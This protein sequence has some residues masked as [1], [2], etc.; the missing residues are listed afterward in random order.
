VRK[1]VFVVGAGASTE[2]GD[3]PVGDTLA[4]ET[5]RLMLAEL[6]SGSRWPEGPISNAIAGHGG[7]DQRHIS[8]MQ[9]IRDGI[10]SCPSIDEFINEWQD[11]PFLPDICKLAIAQIILRAERSSVLAAIENEDSIPA[12][13]LRKLEDSWL[14]ITLSRLGPGLRRR[15]I[16]QRLENV[17]FITFNYDR[18]IEQYLM[19]SFKSTYGMTDSDGAALLASTPVLHVYGSLGSLP[20]GHMGG[21]EFGGSDRMVSYAAKSIRTYTEEIASDHAMQIQSVLRGAEKV[22]FL[23]CAYHQQNLQVLLGS[24][25]SLH[26]VAVWG[27]TY[28]M[29]PIS[30]ERVRAILPNF[31]TLLEP[32]EASELLIRNVEAIFEA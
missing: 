19:A 6:N 29:R 13:L 5:E 12:E 25:A 17:A 1:T 4:R 27:T 24:Q 31:N 21:V 20:Q 22:I 10:Q 2:F 9:R 3:M 11:V 14:G 23:G 30:V 7:L 26:D 32:V 15:D 18:C 8:A 28:R 16:Q